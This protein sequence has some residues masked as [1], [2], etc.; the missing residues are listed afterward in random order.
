MSDGAEEAS[1]VRWRRIPIV[2]WLPRYRT[3]WLRGD[4]VAGAVVAALAVPQA[5]GYA[6]IAGAPVQV[7]LYAVPVALV[8]Y[9]VFGSSRQLVV[10]PVSTVAAASMTV[11]AMAVA[12]VRRERVLHRAAAGHRFALANQWPG[13]Q[14]LISE[15]APGGMS[16]ADRPL[17]FQQEWQIIRLAARRRARADW[18]IRG[19]PTGQ[20]TSTASSGWSIPTAC[21]RTAR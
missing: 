9:A 3:A 5:L 2:S 19:R 15:Y 13:R 1:I 21:R 4:L 17:G 7:G 12:G 16:P 11:A 20:R 10:G 8:A 6:S 18:R 14:L